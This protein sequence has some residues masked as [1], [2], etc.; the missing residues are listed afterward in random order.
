MHPS[1]SNISHQVVPTSLTFKQTSTVQT[2]TKLSNELPGQIGPIVMELVAHSWICT[3]HAGIRQNGLPLELVPSTVFMSH[4]FHLKKC[5]RTCCFFQ[6]IGTPS[7]SRELDQKSHVQNKHK[8]SN[9]LQPNPGSFT[10]SQ[11]ISFCYFSLAGRLR[12][13]HALQA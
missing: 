2:C 9:K 10:G 1:I 5:T 3:Q 11:E 13:C 12:D 4:V 7:F 8:G 6:E